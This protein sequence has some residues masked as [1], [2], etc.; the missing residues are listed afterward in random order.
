[1]Y[2]ITHSLSGRVFNF[3]V[4]HQYQ[5]QNGIHCLPVMQDEN[6]TTIFLLTACF[7]FF[8]LSK[9]LV[10]VFKIPTMLHI[11]FSKLKLPLLQPQV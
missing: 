3:P 11:L 1:M 8:V 4:F 7:F 2:L 9:F 6:I 5:E 10:T